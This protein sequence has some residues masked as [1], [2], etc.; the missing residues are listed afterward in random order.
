MD[1][2]MSP[3][4]LINSIKES[5]VGTRDQQIDL[6]F[7]ALSCPWSPI[8][9]WGPP[10]TGKT[11]IFRRFFDPATGLKIR[12]S[13]INCLEC[14]SERMLF[15]TILRGFMRRDSSSPPSSPL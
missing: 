1:N 7:F 2:E 9:A 4:K 8:Y 13:W 15:E 10:G 6:I 3:L 14:T 12:H 5:F 11:A